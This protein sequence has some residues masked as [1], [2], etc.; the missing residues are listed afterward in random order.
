[1]SIETPTEASP[2]S[3]KGRMA[4]I[5]ASSINPTMVGVDITVASEES[6]SLAR[7][8]VSTI[9]SNLPF[10]PIGTGFIA[11]LSP[12][13]YGVQFLFEPRHAVVAPKRLARHDEGRNTKGAVALAFSEGS[14]HV[15]RAV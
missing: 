14:L 4:S 13:S 9:C 5:A 2:G 8:R 15:A 1:M 10:A 11:Q 12:Q 6:S 7:C 3:R